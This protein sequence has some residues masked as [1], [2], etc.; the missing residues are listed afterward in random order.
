MII[1]GYVHNLKLYNSKPSVA[2]CI[3][4]IK[5]PNNRKKIGYYNQFKKELKGLLTKGCYYS[6]E[7]Y[8]NEKFC[9]IGYR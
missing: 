2:G 5:L 6:T 9:N 4:H 1:I 8:L 7:E 3:F